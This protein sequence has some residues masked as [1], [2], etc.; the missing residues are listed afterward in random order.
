ML[1]CCI[2]YKTGLIYGR[3]TPDSPFDPEAP[4]NNPTDPGKKGFASIKVTKVWKKVENLKA[5][6]VVDIQ[7][8]QNGY[9]YGK[10]IQLKPGTTEYT[11]DNLLRFAPDGSA[12]LYTVSEDNVP[13]GYKMKQDGNV[14]TNTRFIP[15]ENLTIDFNTIRNVGECFE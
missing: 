1:L 15:A 11:W 9:A 13:K 8:K 5:V 2:L 12:Y 6:P 14:I 7:L 10:L 3:I 4:G